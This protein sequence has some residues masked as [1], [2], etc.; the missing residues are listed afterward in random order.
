MAVCH[1]L[2][3]AGIDVRRNGISQAG[4]NTDQSARLW[5]KAAYKAIA[6]AAYKTTAPGGAGAQAPGDGAGRAPGPPRGARPPAGAPSEPLG[7]GSLEPLDGI[8]FR[9]VGAVGWDRV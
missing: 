1:H 9:V 6:T 4:H 2:R 8:G 5:L 3:R 7:L